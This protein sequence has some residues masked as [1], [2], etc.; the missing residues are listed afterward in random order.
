MAAQLGLGHAVP[1]CVTRFLVGARFLV[2]KPL[3]VATTYSP[4]SYGCDSSGAY[5]PAFRRHLEIGKQKL[6]NLAA[7]VSKCCWRRNGF[8]LK[9]LVRVG[10]NEPVVASRLTQADQERSGDKSGHANQPIHSLLA[11]LLPHL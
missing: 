1:C 3:P 7:V 10:G 6:R 11:I 8:P 2:Q 4:S 9:V 5:G